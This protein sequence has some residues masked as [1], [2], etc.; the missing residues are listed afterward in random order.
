M[1][2]PR[3]MC[4]QHPDSTVK[5]PVQEE[6]EEAVRSFLVYG[7]DEVMSDYE[8]KLTP[9]AQPKEIVVKA[10]ELGVPVGEGFYV[11]VRAPNPRLEDFDRVDLAL[12]AAVLANYYSYKRLGVQAVRWVVLPMTDSAETVRLVQ[13][14]LARKTRVLCEEVGQPCEQAQL[15]PLLE[16]VDSLLRVREILRD[17]HSALAELGSDPGVLRVFLGKSDSALKAGHIA[18]ALS[19]LYALGESAKAGEE[20]G[21]EVK[22][23][24]GGGSPPFRGG[25]NN[26]RLVGVEVQRYRGYST[27]TV[28][29][30]V[31]Y[32]ASF[33]EYQ[34]VRSKLLGGA[35]GEPGDAGGRVAELARLAASMYRSLASKYLDFVNEYARSVPTTRDRVSWREYGRALEL[36]DKLFSAPRAIVYTAAWYSL[37]VPPTFLDA[38]FVLEAYRGDFL[39]EVLGYLPGLEEEWRYDAQFYLPRLAG[40][41]LGEELVKKVDEALDAMGL[42]PEPLEPYEKLARTAPAELRALLLG[43]VR[44][45]L[46]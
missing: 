20:L 17:L 37:G 5:V 24:L 46:G 16:D 32:D 38:D 21:L 44:G 40:E 1:E 28:Q 14:L 43:K 11:T 34:E 9:Y 35:G 41:R 30:A 19:L 31:R 29:S 7:C 45:F 8:G 2:T 39:D 33:S 25:V 13:R 18:S 3:L 15:V 26:P 36:E 22:P 27:V 4:T 6:V 42:R 23:I 10:G 12:E